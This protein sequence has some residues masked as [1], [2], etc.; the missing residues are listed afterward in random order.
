LT[1]ANAQL[2]ARARSSVVRTGSRRVNIQVT[3]DAQDGTLV[4]C[5][6]RGDS[7][8][9]AVI[10]RRYQR[11]VWDLAQFTLHNRA[12]AED[13]VQETFLK[14]FRGLR[15]VR[16][17]EALRPWLLTICRHACLDRLRARPSR[18]PLSLDDDETAEPPSPAADHDVRIDFHLAL[19]QLG[20]EEREAFFL[21]DVMGCHSDEAARILGLRAAST[22]RSRVARARSALAP[23]LHGAPEPDCELWGMF[24]SASGSAIVACPCGA[25]PDRRGVA[26]LRAR[27]Q[28]SPLPSLPPGGRD[29][30]DILAFFDRLEQRIPP[31][32][33]R[34]LAVLDEESAGAALAV[35]RWAAEHGRW[36]VR[37]SDSHASWLGEVERMVGMSPV[38]LAR[39]SSEQPFLWTM[40]G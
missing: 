16:R 29:G 13:I 11:D 24:H 32:R 39:L 14:A 23:L 34:V 30:L 19:A 6:R 17:S 2:L 38:P 21:V 26:E 20:S 22:L 27:L 18:P 25:Q 33:R 4:A 10:Y 7:E 5:A 8:A 1:K 12:D 35:A 9:F 15:R 40:T 31:E 37:N 3:N 36:Q 28:G